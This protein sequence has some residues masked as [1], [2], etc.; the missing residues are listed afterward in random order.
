MG[1][2][3]TLCRQ[4]ARDILMPPCAATAGLLALPVQFIGDLVQ[5]ESSPA[6][7]AH[8]RKGALFDCVP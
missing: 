5:R 1:L 7:F 2:L 6:Q 8:D 3:D 4:Q